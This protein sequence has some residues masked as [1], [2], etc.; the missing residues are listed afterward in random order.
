MCFRQHLRPTMFP[1]SCSEL[2]VLLKRLLEYLAMYFRN[3]ATTDPFSAAPVFDPRSATFLGHMTQ[4]THARGTGANSRSIDE[5]A[6]AGPL[7]MLGS[8]VRV[9]TRLR[10]KCWGHTSAYFASKMNH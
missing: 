3:F 4:E 6:D 9:Q 7:M 5:F 8:H 10:S 2:L 1:R